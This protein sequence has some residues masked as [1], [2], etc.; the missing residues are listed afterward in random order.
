MKSK[1][2]KRNEANIRNDKW[3][4]LSAD[5]KLASLNSSQLRASKQRKKLGQIGED[6]K[7]I[8]PANCIY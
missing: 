5:Q 6:R 4:S 1:E 2:V 7:V 3:A 8:I